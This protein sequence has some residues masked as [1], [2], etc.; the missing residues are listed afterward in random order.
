MGEARAQRSSVELPEGVGNLRVLGGSHQGLLLTA[1][2]SSWVYYRI[3][4][5]SKFL[6]C[7]MRVMTAPTSMLL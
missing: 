1:A 2:A 4:P 7:K 5:H 6:A 3:S